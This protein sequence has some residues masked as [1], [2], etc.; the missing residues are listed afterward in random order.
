MAPAPLTHTKAVKGEDTYE[1]FD[2]ALEG[3]FAGRRVTPR[4]SH[5]QAPCTARRCRSI[6][7]R[8]CWSWRC[9]RRS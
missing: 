6:K 7:R 9:P 1:K 2:Q 4:Y 3:W 8:V 5:C